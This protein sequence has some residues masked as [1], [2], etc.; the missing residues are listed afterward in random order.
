MEKKRFYEMMCILDP[1]LDT[2]GVE[3]ELSRVKDIIV[4]GGGEVVEEKV[5]GKRELAYEIN[6]R[7]QGIYVM[8]YFK[9]PGIVPPLLVP[10]FRLE[11][12]VMR[13]IVLQLTENQFNQSRGMLSSS[14]A[15]EEETASS[16]VKE[17]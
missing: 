1:T 15:E 8:V 14:V 7:T 5:W 4:K 2:A 17:D 12:K 9:A 11:P 6:H 3:K 13:Y 16:D 10:H